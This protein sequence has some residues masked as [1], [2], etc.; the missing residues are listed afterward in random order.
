MQISESSGIW[1]FGDDRFIPMHF[2]ATARDLKVLS[3]SDDKQKW[4]EEKDY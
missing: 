4:V 2:N 3:F 1:F